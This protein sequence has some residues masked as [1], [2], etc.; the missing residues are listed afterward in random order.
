MYQV[1]EAPTIQPEVYEEFGCAED[2]NP[3]PNGGRVRDSLKK[4]LK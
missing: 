3:G 1:G 4:R 2:P